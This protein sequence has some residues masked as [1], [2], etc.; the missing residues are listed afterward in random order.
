[1]ISTHDDTVERLVENIGYSGADVREQAD[2]VADEICGA[3][4]AI[5]LAE[6]LLPVMILNTVLQIGQGEAH[7][8]DS[9]CI[10]L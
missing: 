9:K 2:G 8:L 10:H 6:D 5:E 7:V 4:D 1:M 3:E